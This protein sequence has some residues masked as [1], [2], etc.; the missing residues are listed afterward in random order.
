VQSRQDRQGKFLLY[1]RGRNAVSLSPNGQFPIIARP[2]W[3]IAVGPAPPVLSC[4]SYSLGEERRGCCSDCSLAENRCASEIR[5]TSSAIESTAVS[6]R[7]SRPLIALNSRGG[8]GLGSSQRV[9]SRTTGKPRTMM[10]TPGTTQWKIVWRIRF[11]SGGICILCVPV[12][13]PVTTL[14]ARHG[15]VRI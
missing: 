12:G 11:G 10:T 2:A 6:I 14:T 7:S 8:S 9:M 15:F 5:S 3:Q 4:L 1:R 13:D